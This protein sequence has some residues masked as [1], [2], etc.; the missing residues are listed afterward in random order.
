MFLRR[1]YTGLDEQFAGVVTF[2]PA[3]ASD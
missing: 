3:A 1:Y 2:G